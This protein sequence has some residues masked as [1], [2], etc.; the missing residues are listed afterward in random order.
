VDREC[1]AR[2]W[3]VSDN[4]FEVTIHQMRAISS[5]LD[6]TLKKFVRQYLDQQKILNAYRAVTPK[7][8]KE[9]AEPKEK[10]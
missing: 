6:D 3:Q 8:Y 7:E 2:R 9:L 1:E 5:F 10:I 4:D